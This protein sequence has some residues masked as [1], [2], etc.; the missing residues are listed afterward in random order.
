MS[1]TTIEE[2]FVHEISDMYSAEKQM[3]KALPKLAKAAN[4]Q[5]LQKAFISH[6]KE[7]ENQ[8]ARL[9]KIASLCDFKMKRKKCEAMEGLIKEGSSIIQE[10]DEGSIRD[11]ALIS[12]AQKVEHYEISGYLSLM[13][14]AKDLGN[15]KVFA[16]LDRTLSEE[17]GA[18]ETLSH[19]SD[20]ELQHSHEE[21]EDEE[22]GE[23][24]SDENE[25]ELEED[26]EAA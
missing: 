7:T 11:L 23:E 5:S 9:E 2:L 13:K 21:N 24:D 3:A 26:E 14:L 4:D 6:L 1:V 16:L 20:E 8:I 17:E 15:Q 25:E 19:I 22:E 10:L 18:D 12:S